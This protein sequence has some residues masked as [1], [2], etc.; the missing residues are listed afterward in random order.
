MNKKIIIIL[1]II[2]TVIFGCCG[3]GFIINLFSEDTEANIEPQKITLTTNST[4]APAKQ[5]KTPKP[6]IKVLKLTAAELSKEYQKNEIKANNL[7]KDKNVEIKGEIDSITESD[8]LV[9]TVLIR[10]KGYN[11]NAISCSM[12]SRKGL[13]NYNIGDKVT[14]RGK[15][16]GI[17]IFDVFVTDCEMI[18]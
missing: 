13:E 8:F 9:D 15:I 17:S 7:Y 5:T 1:I 3:G 11:Y 4:A 12:K 6:T 10:L 16:D 18:K 14:I 2:A